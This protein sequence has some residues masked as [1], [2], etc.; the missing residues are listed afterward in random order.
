[1]SRRPQV[2]PAR[3]VRERACARPATLGAPVTLML[4]ALLAAVA[5]ALLGGCA[6]SGTGTG[7]RSGASSSAEA[8]P[9]AQLAAVQVR[10]YKGKKLSSIEDFREN[11]IKGPQ[12]VDL[13]TYK[14]KLTGEVT[15]ETT[16]SYAEVVALP[17]FQKA[18]TLNCVEGWSADILWRGVRLKDVINKAGVGSKANT[19]IFHCYD[20]YTTSLPLSF[21]LDRDILLANQ[22]NG[23]YLPSERGF[24]F[25]VVAESKLGY[26]WAKWVTEIELSSD[27]NYRG[28]WEQRGY[29]NTA[30]FR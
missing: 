10:E 19:V 24:P 6:P 20:G 1:M 7:T 25:Q 15:T 26:K 8:T 3:V 9:I 2:A 17:T 14:L 18:V 13:S 16:L 28:Y 30:D 23:V 22:M 12:V 27:S 5:L 11:S 29:D 4:A 21:V